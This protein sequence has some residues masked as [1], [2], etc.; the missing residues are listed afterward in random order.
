M[1]IKGNVKID[2]PL[3]ELE[4]LLMNI[5]WAR[6]SCTVKE[7]QKEITKE[8]ELAYTS[9]ATVMKIL[10]SKGVL[11]ST[12][13]DKA[14]IYS[15]LVSK[16]NYEKLSLN[17]LAENLFQGDSSMMVMRLIN[18]SNISLKDLESI[19]DILN[20]RLLK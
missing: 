17:H 14:H 15:P 2:K 12:K 3:T 6:G 19:R 18:D 9:V 20:S 10:E 4:L 11:K 5:I 1:P 16:E 13:N 8:R 7:V